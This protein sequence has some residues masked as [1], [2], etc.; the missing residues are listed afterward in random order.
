MKVTGARWNNDTKRFCVDFDDGITLLISDQHE[1]E[2][3]LSV[4]LDSYFIC[5]GKWPAG[6]NLSR[7]RE[8][9][10]EWVEK[11]KHRYKSYNK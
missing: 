9:A 7:R 8:M 1:V 3:M 11:N 6:T 5:K 4:G 2:N 10:I